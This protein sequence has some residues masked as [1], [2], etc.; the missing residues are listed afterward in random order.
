[1]AEYIATDHVL[2]RSLRAQRMFLDRFNPLERI[3][4]EEEVHTRFRFR[5][6]T[7]YFILRL[8][9]P[10]IRRPIRRSNALPPLV[11]LCCAPRY[12]ASGS[13]YLVL[14]DCMNTSQSSYCRAIHSVT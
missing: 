4:S 1:M 7:I 2:A 10:D 11:V 3:R 5:C 8:I 14:G 12:Y 9:L 6:P 13:F